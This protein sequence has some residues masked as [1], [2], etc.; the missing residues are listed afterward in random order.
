MRIFIPKIGHRVVFV[1]NRENPAQACFW[2]ID[3]ARFSTPITGAPAWIFFLKPPG[4]PHEYRP[5]L[6]KSP[7]IRPSR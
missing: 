3:L 4:R 2:G 7:D 5:K 1:E 6:Q